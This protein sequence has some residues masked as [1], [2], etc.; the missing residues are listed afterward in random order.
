MPAA[1]RSSSCRGSRIAARL[2]RN[3]SD[4]GVGSGVL[5]RIGE[6]PSSILAV[7]GWMP[8][9]PTASQ[10]AKLV[11]LKSPEKERAFMGQATIVGVD[12]AKRVFQVHGA[13]A[14]GAVMFRVK[15]TRA[16]FLAFL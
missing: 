15:L 9:T 10:C 13:A 3:M 6:A 16:R 8:P 14:D 7:M 1:S 11:M 5:G 2:S 4:C 12:L